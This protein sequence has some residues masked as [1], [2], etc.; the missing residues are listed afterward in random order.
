MAN[1]KVEAA[2]AGSIADPAIAQRARGRLIRPPMIYFCLVSLIPA[3]CIGCLFVASRTVRVA[4]VDPITIDTGII[5]TSR[6]SKCC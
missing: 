5:E 6:F 4:A 1:D 2:A 3:E